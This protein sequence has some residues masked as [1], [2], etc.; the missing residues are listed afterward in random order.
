MGWSEHSA[1][2]W[3]LSIFSCFCVGYGYSQI[4]HGAYASSLSWT[5]HTPTRT[6]CARPCRRATCF[7]ASVWNGRLTNRYQQLT[8]LVKARQSIS[9][10]VGIRFTRGMASAALAFK[11]RMYAHFSARL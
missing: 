10:A 11:R 9:N 8:L 5:S 7:S 6:A 2:L 1:G 4:R 3:R